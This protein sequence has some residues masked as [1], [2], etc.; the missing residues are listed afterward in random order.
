MHCWLFFFFFFFFSIVKGQDERE[1]HQKAILIDLHNDVLSESIMRGKDIAK[2]LKTGHTDIPRLKKG[3][4]DVQ[5]FSVWCDGKKVNP[6][7][8]A[9]Q[10]MDA[11]YK[12]IQENEADIM[13][14]TDAEGIEKGQKEHKIVA[15]IGVEGGHMIEDNI[16]YIDSLYRRGARYL[17]LTWNN[18]TSWASSAADEHKAKI[19]KKGLSELGES[20]VGR[21]NKLGMM[22][23]LSHVGEQTFYDVIAC[24]TK[25]V[26]VSHSDVYKINPHYRNLK[27]EQIKALAK[28][29]GVIGIN[30]YSDF[31]DPHYRRKISALY[32]QYVRHADSVELSIDR[33][34]DLLPQEAKERVRPPLSLVIDHINYIVGLVGVDYVGIGADFDGMDSTPLGLDGV[35]NYPLL[36]KALLQCGYSTQDIYKILGGNVLRVIKAQ[37]N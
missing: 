8:Y 22:I 25:P 30:F 2:E 11:L 5:F 13:L 10:Q 17:T 3:G 23:D 31:L 28:N 27:D 20:I 36:T 18:S 7:R 24:S 29:G 1:I 4:V 33:K 12:V 14:A 34:F 6:F 21:M 15:L 9:N 35:Q 32:K 26:L 16:N 37:E 19:K